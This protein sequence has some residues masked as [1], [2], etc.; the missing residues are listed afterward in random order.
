M[1][2]RCRKALAPKAREAVLPEYRCRKAPAQ[3]A[4]GAFRAFPIPEKPRANPNAEVFEEIVVSRRFHWIRIR[5]STPLLAMPAGDHEFWAMAE[6]K[7]DFRC[8]LKD[9]I[10]HYFLEL[11]VLRS[12]ISSLSVLRIDLLPDLQ[13]ANSGST[14]AHWSSYRKVD[15]AGMAGNVV[16]RRFRHNFQNSLWRPC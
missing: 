2:G 1:T 9:S 13:Q 3:R 7:F 15:G 11:Y 6:I 14:R 5:E 16:L 12:F 10:Q 4:G 8:K